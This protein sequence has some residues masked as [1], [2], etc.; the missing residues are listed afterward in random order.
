M[1][2]F[3]QLKPPGWNCKFGEGALACACLWLV[4]HASFCD[5]CIWP[6]AFV[7]IFRVRLSAI[8]KARPAG[9]ATKAPGLGGLAACLELCDSFI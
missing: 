3:V 2:L 1:M 6:R 5:A 4:G 7:E 9:V 8:E